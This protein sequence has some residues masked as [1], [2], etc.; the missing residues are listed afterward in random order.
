MV[1]NGVGRALSKLSPESHVKKK[2]KKTPKKTKT[3]E[4]S[5]TKRSSN[6]KGGPH[7]PKGRLG[8]VSRASQTGK[9]VKSLQTPGTEKKRGP[10]KKYTDNTLKKRGVWEGGEHK[11]VNALRA[12]DG[13]I[14]GG[15]RPV[16]KK[17]GIEEKGTGR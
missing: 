16:G 5:H 11:K 8:A 17:K 9:S 2:K 3:Q 13:P 6:S 7:C 4:Q 10:V 14:W 15:R 1:P 12:I